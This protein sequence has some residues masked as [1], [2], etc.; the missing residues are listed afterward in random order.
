[1]SADTFTF[2]E[3]DQEGLETLEALSNSENFNRW[4]FKSIEPHASGRIL[5]IG[6]GLGN[7]SRF[8]IEKGADIILSDLRDNYLEQIQKRFTQDLQM[9]TMD[10]VHPNFEQVYQDELESFD[11]VFALN[12]VEHIKD[13]KQ[14]LFNANRLLKPGGTLIILVPAYQALY[15][16]FDA[17]LHHYRRYRI[18][19]L[20]ALFTAN[21]FNV[22]KRFYFNFT[23]IFGWF[24]T[25]RILKRKV[26]PAGQMALFDKVVPVLRLIDKI[27]M[28]L[29]GLSVIVIGKKPRVS[30]KN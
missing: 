24:L 26:I 30:P 8:F 21:E 19:T 2:K 13:D 14:A 22:I 6:S 5:E 1:M 3:V 7:I 27:I 9:I 12:V 28:N 18:S 16:R 20:E 23:G 15:N 10:L 29:A 4:M 25:G 17:E 11:T